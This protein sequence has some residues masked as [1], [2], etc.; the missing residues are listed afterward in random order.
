MLPEEV[1]MS[2][3][4][5]NAAF[6]NIDKTIEYYENLYPKR[7]LPEGAI[8]TRF[9]PSP[10]GFVHIGSLNT[11]NFASRMAKQSGGIYYLR[12]E[13]TDGKREVE[14]G[15][16]GIIE[17]LRLFDVKFDEG[18]ISEN[19]ETGN[20]G[21]Y[22]QSHRKEIYQTF[23]KSLV[24]KG[25]AYPC[26]CTEED[27]NE[28]R[29]KQE[30]LK[31]RPGYYGPFTRCRT[32][33]ESQMLERINNGDSFI[34]RLRSNGDPNKKIR[35]DDLIRGVI[36]FPENDQDIVIIKSDGLP[37]YHFAHAIDDHLMRTTHVVRGDEWISSVPIHLQ[38]FD[39]LGF[40][41]PKFMHVSPVMKD[42]NGS[43]RKLSKRKDPESAVLYYVDQG[44]PKES[45]IDYL[46]N[47]T[48]SNYEDWRRENP[49]APS[50]DFKVTVE[51][52]SVSGA[53]FD[54]VKLVDVSKNM[55]ATFSAEKVYN[56]GLEWAKEYD[57]ELADLMERN[58]EFTISILNIERTGTKVRK[59]ISKWS[60]LKENLEYLY[61]EIFL[62]NNRE[63]EWQNI[64][65]K[66]EI[67][68]IL[69]EYEKIYNIS[70]DKDTWFNKIKDVS[71][72]FGYA[73]EVKDYKKNPEN[74]KGHVGD[75][76]TVIRVALT[77]RKN[78]P[79]LY[80]ILKNLGVDSM[81]ARF[82]KVI[83]G[84][85]YWSERPNRLDH[86]NGSVPVCMD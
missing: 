40:E 29:E 32:M 35:F 9:A 13:D 33:S 16:T 63:Y 19:E 73:R 85:T 26:F 45:V 56:D 50:D 46:L 82:E 71:E 49:T 14:N 77:G 27:L 12:I 54:L 23:A 8:V 10:T 55:I 34:I 60:D 52:M 76:S 48:N 79:D 64:T 22:I 66:N 43:R 37:T 2:K 36:E 39:M 68:N 84:R 78:T 70:D 4:L 38:L 75:I 7:N 53:L 11:A 80:E 58:K 21:P 61:D 72:K 57:K 25:L 74:F 69:S 6:P 31:I 65:D 24:E 81:K 86:H 51:K 18:P 59:D 62:A 20:Y 42:D 67:R 15:I 28:I 5:A 83:G 17:G 44:V 41:T 1:K 30:K 3:E 47:I